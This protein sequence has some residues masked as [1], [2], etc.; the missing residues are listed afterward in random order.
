MIS[1]LT[2]KLQSDLFPIN[3]IVSLRNS[4]ILHFN[5]SWV[6]H[7]FK[8]EENYKRFFGGKRKAK[9]AVSANDAQEHIV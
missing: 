5:R 4:L 8:Y 6:H 2:I 3:R 9:I 7:H 1:I